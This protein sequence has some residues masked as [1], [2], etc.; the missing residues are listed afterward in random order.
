M[1]GNLKSHLTT[2]C[3]H[4]LRP[5]VSLLLRYGMAYGEFAEVVKS[6][7]AE[8]ARENFTPKGDKPSDSRVAIITGLTRKEV[9]RLREAGIDTKA[10]SNVNRATR[11]LS[12]WYQD[13]E[14]TGDDGQP[15]PLRLEGT[16]ISFSTLVRRYSGDMPPKTMLEE[17]HRVHAVDRADDGYI[18]VLSRAYLPDYDDPSG[19]NEFGV[20]LHDLVATIDHNLN[21][22]REGA[23]Y[24]QRMVANERVRVRSLP[25]FRRIVG[26]RGQQLLETLDDWLNLHEV[27]DA[28]ADDKHVRTG[29]GIYFFQDSD[30]SETKK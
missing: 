1:K 18:H 4:L 7:Y 12:G 22:Q 6:V 14:F 15:L 23:L 11:V 5:L 30:Q 29:V 16:G 20:A 27:D 8:V 9:K 28:K 21:P 26:E 24:F 10:S 13:A 3:R 25:V 2:A 19:I 17:L